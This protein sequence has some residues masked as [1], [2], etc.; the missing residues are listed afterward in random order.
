MNTFFCSDPHYN[1]KNIVNCLSTWAEGGQREFASLE[2]MNNTLV[3]NINNKVGQ[4]DVLYCLGD[5]SFG[6][7]ESIWEFRQ[8]INCQNIHLILGNHDHHIQNNRLVEIGRPDPVWASSLF[9]SVAYYKEIVVN[10]QNLVLFHYPIASWNGIAKGWIQLHGHIHSDRIGPGKMMD[11]GFDSN[12]KFEPYSMDEI[13]AIMN[14]QPK[15]SML[16]EDHHE[17]NR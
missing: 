1:H 2:Q 17:R 8:Q 13:M 7:I 10:K 4:N 12:P 11:V 15:A 6:G 16:E 3:N 14:S 9:S 5:W